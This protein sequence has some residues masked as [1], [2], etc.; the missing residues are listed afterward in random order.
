MVLRVLKLSRWVATGIRAS[1]PYSALSRKKCCKRDSR[2]EAGSSGYV[3]L[4]KMM[5]TPLSLE[6][7]NLP[8]RTPDVWEKDDAV[9]CSP[10]GQGD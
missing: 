1:P 10:V 7:G 3:K 6:A 2:E 5:F 4:A 9:P 8:Q